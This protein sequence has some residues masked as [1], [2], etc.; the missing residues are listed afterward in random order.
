MTLI[1]RLSVHH[2]L[3]GLAIGFF[4]TVQTLFL[5]EKGLTLWHLGILFGA[6]SVSAAL[7]ELPLGLAADRVG[8]IRLYAWAR[9]V[10][11]L[12][13]MLAIFVD[14]FSLLLGV[15]ALLGASRALDSGSIE[16]WQ[17]EQL[18]QTESAAALPRRLAGFHSLSALAMA[19]GALAGGYL[20][21]AM[22]PWTPENM[23]PTEWNLIAQAIIT[24]LHLLLIPVLFCEPAVIPT[25]RSGILAPR[26]KP[27]LMLA[28]QLRPVRRLLGVAL[29][30]G[31]LLFALETY[32]QPR[33]FAL[34]PSAGY[35]VFGW[36]VTGYFLAA[37]AGPALLASLL[38]RCSV[39]SDRIMVVTLLLISPA[40]TALAL[41]STLPGF[42]SGYLGVM[43]IAAMLSVPMEAL[44]AE[45][46]PGPVR[47][48]LYSLLSLALQAGGVIL[49]V[50]LSWLVPILGIE[51]FWLALAAM[52]LL[53]GICAHLDLHRER[54]A[55]NA[56]AKP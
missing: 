9:L 17:S 11:L 7:L 8:R 47:S 13:T 5:Q 55:A 27:A 12:G 19:G 24:L 33:A 35:A 50:G 43:L 26:M 41:Q 1:Q 36:L 44:I 29:S 32:W 48:T 10:G 51:G 45:H 40:L 53:V 46:V 4:L 6:F 28:W 25:T 52:L 34:A 3:K 20:A 31:M 2:S 30:L 22:T 15:M 21:D 23:Q 56:R 42:A 16:A 38:K 49:L 37:A 39:S 14:Q 18:Q 54:K